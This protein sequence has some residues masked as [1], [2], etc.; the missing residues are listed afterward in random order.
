MNKARRK[1]IDEVL[2][3]L[4]AL[5]AD[6]EELQAEEQEA[7]DNLTEGLQATPNGQ[8]MEEAADCLQQALDGLGDVIANLE[9]A[10]GQG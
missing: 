3:K 10:A 8:A 7:F 1:T 4:H 5:E 6:I 9:Q 2:G